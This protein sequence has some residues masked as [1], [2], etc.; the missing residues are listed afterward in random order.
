MN[1]A[2]LK[3][4]HPALW[5]AVVRYPGGLCATDV[6][7]DPRPLLVLKMPH[8]F[9][10]TA[11][12]NGGFKMFV[13]PVESDGVATIG[14]ML[15]FEDA[16][17][18]PLNLWT[19]LANEP[20]SHKLIRCF[21]F[22]QTVVV[23]LIDEH[24]REFLAYECSVRV[25]LESKIRLE[26]AR[27]FP[28]EDRLARSFAQAAQTWF[29]ASNAE[30]EQAAID[31]RFNTPLYAE[32]RVFR[33]ERPELFRFRGAKGFAE[34]PLVRTEP[35]QFQELDIILL[36]QRTFAPEQLYHA[37]LRLNDRKEIC[38][39]MVITDTLCLVIQ[40]KD[41]PNT[42][43]MLAN[44][45]ERKVLKSKSQL[46]AGCAQVKGA[47]GYLK[48]TR[49]L[50]LLIDGEEEV[51]D[52]GQRQVLSLVVVRELFQFEYEEYSQTLLALHEH[53][54]LPCIALDYSELIQYCTLLRSEQDFL[55]AYYQVFDYALKG[56]Q[57]PRLRFGVRDLFDVDGNFKFD[58]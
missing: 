1:G 28:T 16:S 55:G 44:S 54:G 50:R 56:G 29:S 6:P 47:I 35:G 41:S 10:L 33:D 57:F 13:V 17:A 45:L 49:P 48:R 52:L 58:S 43:A 21:R 9:L 3:D 34:V 53:T 23:R 39:V 7:G 11:R 14:L 42:E 25:P 22:H 37:P 31:V 15:V 40:A 12:V 8:Q 51:I 36:L 4:I 20:E 2:L 32:G 18:S 30:D 38:D 5:E 46:S 26:L 19:P 24:D 27:L